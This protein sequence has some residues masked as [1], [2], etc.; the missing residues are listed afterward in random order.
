M[1][2][3]VLDES[4][5][6]KARAEEQVH[7]QKTETTLFE[8]RAKATE[9]RYRALFELAAEGILICSPHGEILELNEKARRILA[10]GEGKVK[11]VDF[12]S[13]LQMEEGAFES[14]GRDEDRMSGLL[15][16][17]QV[18]LKNWEGRSVMVDLEGAK[19]L[20]EDEKEAYQVFI[21]DRSNKAQLEQQLRQAEKLSALGQMISG[22][23][24][25]LN[26]P[27]AAIKGYLELF[28]NDPRLPDRTRQD[29]RKVMRE[30]QRA[31]KL[32]TNFL[33]FARERPASREIADLNQIVNRVVEMR[34]FECR[35][36]GV[37]VDCMLAGKLHPAELDVDQ[38]QQVL[39]NLINNSIQAMIE[40]PAPHR[41]VIRTWNDGDRVRLSVQDTGPGIPEAQL[42]KIFEP[43]FT[44]KDVGSGTGLG[45]SIAHSIMRDHGGIIAYHDG[46][47]GGACFELDFTA[48]EGAE[49]TYVSEDEPSEGE[50]SE[51]GVLTPS[52]DEGNGRILVVDD[53]ES[54][55]ELLKELLM[56]LGHD[57][58]M[59]HSARH[60]LKQLEQESFEVILSD[61][62]MPGMDG[63]AF[64][65]EAMKIDPAFADRFIFLTGDLVNGETQ[66]FIRSINAP[67][68][69]K[70]FQ[71][72]DVR[73]AV[74]EVLESVAGRDKS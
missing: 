26:N 52:S 7:L 19:L 14:D 36:A 18:R 31:A 59:C 69:D 33:S 9:K 62:R 44:T 21:R 3:L 5:R 49:L 42:S 39:V 38:V 15:E 20:W 27:L 12:F 63:R 37:D 41:I 32:V 1:V 25:E 60:A 47:E 48:K 28:V 64:Y 23:A 2:V 24:H 56:I 73:R 22:I 51:T 70:P 43:F 11:G 55:A 45:L 67:C 50:L 57:V 58:T 74:N 66:E 53:E 68:V 10:G 8:N 30:S 4:R 13:F 16:A 34:Q 71:L 6:W 46:E 54:I 72:E 61:F 17:V 65:E 35:I 29:L 40:T